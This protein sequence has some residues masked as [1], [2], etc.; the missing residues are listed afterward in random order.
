MRCHFQLPRIYGPDE[1]MWGE[2]EFGG[3]GKGA[4]SDRGCLNNLGFTRRRRAAK[5][6]MSERQVGLAAELLVPLIKTLQGE[7]ARSAFL[8]LIHLAACRKKKP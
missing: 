6:R 3:G 1:C 8:S 2:G 4:L 5:N 7:A